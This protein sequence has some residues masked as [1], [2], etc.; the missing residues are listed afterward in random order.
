LAS[1][2]DGNRLLDQYNSNAL[3]HPH[4]PDFRWADG[5]WR[6]VHHHGFID[7]TEMLLR[8]QQAVLAHPMK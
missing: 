5:A 1:L 3:Y 2:D 4:H 6:Q 7:D 8:Y